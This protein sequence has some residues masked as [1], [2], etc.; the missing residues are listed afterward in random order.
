MAKTKAQAQLIE[1]I[2]TFLFGIL[3]LVTISTL[4]YTF[5][6]RALKIEIEQSLNQ[7]AVQIAEGIIKAY[8]NAQNIKSQPS[9]MTSQLLYELNLNLPR[10]I[11][12]KN[13]EVIFVT[14]N[15]VWGSVGSI[16]INGQSVTPLVKTPGAKI[17]AKTTQDPEVTVEYDVPNINVILQGMCQ[18]G[19]NG[20]LRYYRVN[21]NGNLNDIIVI[22]N[23]ELLTT[24]TSVV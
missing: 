6:S 20:K 3:V 10:A 14:S 7:L 23:P 5:Y 9:N 1:Y 4:F 12:N 8:E 2:L 19:V 24:I 11:S 21:I 13:Y 18:N 22:G 17:I 15:P 16:V